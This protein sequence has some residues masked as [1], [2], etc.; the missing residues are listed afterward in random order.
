MQALLFKAKSASASSFIKLSAHL[1]FLFMRSG[2]QLKT[3]LI[4]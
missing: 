3:Y 1:H 4:S 2:E